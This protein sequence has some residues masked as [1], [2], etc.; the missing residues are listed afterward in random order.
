M[1]E[2]EIKAKIVS[3]GTNDCIDFDEKIPFLKDG[4][5]LVYRPARDGSII[6]R[7]YE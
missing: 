4:D 6:V 7:H 3:T 5:K 1:E 2:K